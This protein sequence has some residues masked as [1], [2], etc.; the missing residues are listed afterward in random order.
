MHVVLFT[1]LAF[2]YSLSY[3]KEWAQLYKTHFKQSKDWLYTLRTR[4]NPSELA[5]TPREFASS[6]TTPTLRRTPP[7][8]RRSVPNVRRRL[9]GF[10]RVRAY[11]AANWRTVRQKIRSPEEIPTISNVRSP[12]ANCSSPK[13]VFW[14]IE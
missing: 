13:S 8:V 7:N 10:A 14:M 12:M 11:S 1:V 3:L 6:S 2:T 4:A 5:R 9:L